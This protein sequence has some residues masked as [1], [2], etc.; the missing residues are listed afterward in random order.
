MSIAT[1]INE[2]NDPKGPFSGTWKPMNPKAEAADKARA[3]DADARTKANAN[4]KAEADERAA[5]SGA[6]RS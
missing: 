2:D 4:A 5:V 3:A 1:Y 6:W